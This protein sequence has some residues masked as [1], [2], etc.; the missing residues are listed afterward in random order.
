M[1]DMIEADQRAVVG[2][3]FRVNI[4]RHACDLPRLERFGDCAF[5]PDAA[6]GGVDDSCAGLKLRDSLGTKQAACFAGDGDMQADKVAAPEQFVQVQQPDTLVADLFFAHIRVTGQH[7]H[8]E[9]QTA[10]GDDAP[11][12]AKADEADGF[13]VKLGACL[14]FAVKQPVTLF[15][16][17]VGR[18]Q[19]AAE[20]QHERQRVFA[21]SDG[22]GAGRVGDDD[23]AIGGGVDINA[24]QPSPDPP[25]DLEPGGM[26]EQGG[27][28]MNI[29]TGD[30]RLCPGDALTQGGQAG[31][32]L[33][34]RDTMGLF[35]DLQAVVGQISCDQ[36][37][38]KTQD[39][40]LTLRDKLYTGLFCQ[41]VIVPTFQR[42]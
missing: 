6:V 16:A 28:D 14:P 36:N 33:I 32:N 19:L 5:I 29:F 38:V 34:H 1:D 23:A 41:G 31:R 7:G 20:G 17:V 24:A 10:L 40:N 42:V 25:D 13:A 22:V 21:G 4:D 11:D 12:T 30:D 8:A 39:N 2:R 3:F 9:R 27:V 26:I 15:Q 35:Q 18:Y 37:V